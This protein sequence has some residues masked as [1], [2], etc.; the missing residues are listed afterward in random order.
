[1]KNIAVLLM[2]IV[3]TSLIMG[4]TQ[5]ASNLSASKDSI[6]E[7][8]SQS[9]DE[10]TNENVIKIIP[11]DTTDKELET[12]SVLTSQTDERLERQRIL[13]NQLEILIPKGF[14]EESTNDQEIKYHDKAA[15]VTINIKHDP[16]QR[17]DEQA[18][19]DENSGKKMT[20]ILKQNYQGAE[21]ISEEVREV[22]GKHI[23]VSEIASKDQYVLLSWSSLNNGLLEIEISSPIGKKEE[24]SVLAN[25]IIDSIQMK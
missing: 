16:E 21:V 24:W 23:A 7:Q 17:V 9:I 14:K 1:M 8:G 4:C 12:K 11:A 22:G 15:Q 13:S 2:F 19:K 25:K 6:V 5:A 18:A 10:S 20:A 3:F